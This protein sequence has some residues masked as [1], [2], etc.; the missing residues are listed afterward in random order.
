MNILGIS[1][2]YHDASAC[3]L[4]DG[5]VATAADEERFTRIKHDNNFPINAINY[6]L[7][8]GGIS[9]ED[10]DYVGFYE[11]PIM[12]FDRVLS[13]YLETFPRSFKMFVDTMPSFLAEKLRIH[14]KIRKELKYEGEIFFIDHHL[15][16]AAS[17]FLTSSF[18]KSAILTIDAV[19]E[20]A[21]TSIGF[22]EGNVIKILK[23]IRF[24][25]SLGLLYTT[26]TAYL[27]FKAN[28][29]EYKVMGL[30][31]YGKPKYSEKF[32]KIIH[33]KEDGSFCLDMSYFDYHHKLRMPSKKFIE[34]FGPERE[35][36]SK[37]KPRHEDIAASLQKITEEVIFKMLNHLYDLTR[38]ENLCMAGGVALNSVANGKITEN[39]PFKNIY[40]QPA[41]SD[42]GTSMGAALFVYTSILGKDRAYVLDS[43]YLGPSFL[44]EDVEKFLKNKNAVYREFQND[45]EL[46]KKIAELV[47]KNKIVAL[48]RGSMEW[49]PRALGNRTILANPC[50]PEMKDILNRRVKHRE[51]FRPFA[52][53][54]PLED[55]EKYFDTDMPV[56]HMNIVYPVKEE[57][58]KIIPSVTHVD[59]SGRIQTV[60]KKQNPFFHKVLKE[61]E[62]LSGVPILINT[63]FNVRGEPIVCSPEDAY[64]CMMGTG[65]DFMA[66]ENFLVSK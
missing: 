43:A 17:A 34:E 33:V 24:P 40:V 15:A 22:G 1:C 7:K 29:D 42:S 53:T 14:S 20:W 27:G 61:F 54:V 35:P 37:I 21:T 8:E 3:L 47:W 58:R 66:I 46:A 64:K 57:K 26:V 41:S 10:V 56:P 9:I 55:A 60:T 39:T 16:H 48:F 2:Y 31:A 25:H 63:S 45:K 49:G 4:K 59:G 36:E 62:K 44:K 12:K 11:K 52:P 30:A 28:N 18:K 38:V 51:P 5:K 65:I 19:G 6:C 23:E 32:K 13:Q 50:N